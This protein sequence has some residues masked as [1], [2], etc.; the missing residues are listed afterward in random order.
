MAITK[1]TGSRGEKQ[2][3]FLKKCPQCKSIGELTSL[4]GTC[5]LVIKPEEAA[6]LGEAVPKGPRLLIDD[7]LKS[8]SAGNPTGDKRGM[9]CKNCRYYPIFDSQCPECGSSDLISWEEAN[10]QSGGGGKGGGIVYR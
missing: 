4:A 7:E 2:G 1:L 5:G 8:V 6:E 3:E 9:V 10:P